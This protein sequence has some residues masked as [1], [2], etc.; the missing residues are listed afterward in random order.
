MVY[1]LGALYSRKKRVNMSINSEVLH[2]M[3]VVARAYNCSRSEF[4]EYLYRDW[5]SRHDE[6]VRKVLAEW[7]ADDE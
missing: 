4:V 1:S 7:S 3:T 5:V 6:D 2:D